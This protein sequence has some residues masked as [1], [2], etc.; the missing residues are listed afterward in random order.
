MTATRDRTPLPPKARRI[1]KAQSQVYAT[2]VARFTT[3]IA[4]FSTV[5]SLTAARTL[6]TKVAEDL[7]PGSLP[8]AQ[9]SQILANPSARNFCP[10]CG[11]LNLS[12]THCPLEDI[13]E[14][15]HA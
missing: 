11:I 6:A 2:Q 1:I 5:E 3:V 10:Y 9:A 13:G 8:W 7:T 12:D 15:C 14:D 4:A